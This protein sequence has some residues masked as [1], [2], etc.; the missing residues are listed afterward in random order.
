MYV[1]FFICIKYLYM[2]TIIFFCTKKRFIRKRSAREREKFLVFFSVS[3]L[4]LI[5][6]FLVSCFLFFFSFSIFCMCV[7][8]LMVFLFRKI[9]RSKLLLI[10]TR[11]FRYHQ[12]RL[13]RLYSCIPIRKST[14][15]YI[16]HSDTPNVF[17]TIFFC[18]EDEWR[19]IL[20]TKH[21]STYIFRI[22]R[23]ILHIGS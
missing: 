19:K 20:Y 23:V 9:L 21:N 12:H 6:F 22:E 10:R 7:F 1:Q 3:F 4:L 14:Y 18:L 13:Q 5:F 17:L 2:R 8:L 15:S 11:M 16:R